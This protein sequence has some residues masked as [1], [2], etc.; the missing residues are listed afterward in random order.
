[1]GKYQAR[2]APPP[3]RP[4]NVHPIWRGIGCLL[5]LFGPPLSLA[6]GHLLVEMNSQ[7]GWYRIP[8]DLMTRFV[9]PGVNFVVPHLYATLL[10]GGLLMVLGI[11]VIMIIYALM[12]SILGPKRYGPMDSPPVRRT[13]TKSKR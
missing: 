4:Y 6:L 8:R 3:Q 2:Q 13:S 10:A 5:V 11:G 9:V 7:E 12:Y 1:M